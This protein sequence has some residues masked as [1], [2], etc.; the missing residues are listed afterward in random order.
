MEGKGLDFDAPLLSVRRFTSAPPPAPPSSDPGRGAGAGGRPV[1]GERPRRAS[2]PFYRSD[3][4]S[5]PVRNPGV[6][7]FVW[8]QSPGLPKGGAVVGG[9]HA[10]PVGTPAAAPKP[11]PGRIWRRPPDQK[12]EPVGTDAMDSANNGALPRTTTAATASSSTPKGTSSKPPESAREDS[13]GEAKAK[14][15]VGL[16]AEA[17]ILDEQRGSFE[18][19][20]EVEEEDAFS[21][22]METLSRT[23]SCFMNCSISGLTGAMEARQPSGVFSTDPQV[24]D[25]MMGRFLPAAQAVATGSPQCA[26]RKPP[27]PGRDPPRRVVEKGGEPR[28]PAV[29][30]P[31]QHRPAHASAFP[32]LHH[33]TDVGNVGD[34]DDGS[35]TC[36]D[37]D[38]LP[39][40]GCGLL[41]RFCLKGS[42]GLLN[43]VSGV[44][45][46]GRM[47][48][49]AARRRSPQLTTSHHGSLGAAQDEHTWEEVYKYKLG[50]LHRQVGEE[51][52]K[53]TSESNQLSY[54]SVSQTPDG[55]SPYRRSTAGG[56]SPHRN[57]MPPSPSREGKGFLPT[58]KC[59]DRAGEDYVASELCAKG[60]G[61]YWE[62][63]PTINS[64]QA[65]GSLSPVVE[66][67]VY[68]DS[69]QVLGNPHFQP[70]YSD[71]KAV[72]S[73]SDKN[74]EIGGGSQRIEISPISGTC[75]GD[76]LQHKIFAVVDADELHSADQ[77]GPVEQMNY[78]IDS[79][80]NHLLCGPEP[81]KADEQGK[82]DNNVLQAL[83]P[84]PLPKS[85]S[86][87]W[88]WRTLPSMSAKNSNPQSFL[89]FQ[90]HPTK[91]VV[92]TSSTDPRWETIV[93]TTVLPREHMRFADV[94]AKPA[95]EN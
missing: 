33:P 74:S 21:D 56:I 37:A 59:G 72:A 13:K 14:Q 49:P 89:G 39:V 67:T 79:K 5:G 45:V 42:F 8:E 24:R 32:R 57:D 81:L 2:L 63:T 12:E 87:S 77:S 18:E 92:R 52:R 10:G 58:P 34:E 54:W 28:R 60:S 73:C 50:R 47:P 9:S 19:E 23:E 71:T 44:K 95:N 30:L 11:P 3:L 40:K 43:P 70:C 88:L 15:V 61:G 82:N 90:F 69:V 46:S 84:P 36:D 94:L 51:G 26:P 78:I 6:V 68:V 66:K 16:V 22:A 85:P 4:R 91:Q 25:F 31:Y 48:L 75:E 83:L 41:P 29:P 17:A 86:E 1:A 80:Q 27:V 62:I 65:S 93:K 38:D 64:K 35:D 7:P 20:G 55:S 53:I 76:A